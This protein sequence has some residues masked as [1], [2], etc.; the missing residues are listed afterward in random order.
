MLRHGAHSEFLHVPMENENCYTIGVPG[1]PAVPAGDTFARFC[2]NPNVSS[3]NHTKGFASMVEPATNFML[4]A[5]ESHADS[6]TYT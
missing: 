3:I 4:S 5:F 6:S 1:D 2:S